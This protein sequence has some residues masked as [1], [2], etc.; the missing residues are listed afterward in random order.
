MSK[1][2]YYGLKNQNE[3]MAAAARATRT[4]GGDDAVFCLLVGT[5]CTETDMG[6]FRDRHPD[7]LGVGLNQFDEI[8]FTDL[9]ARTRRTNAAKFR[10][11]YGVELRDL[12]LEDLAN[13]PYLSMACCRLAYILV[14]EPIP[15]S[16][17]GQAA[18]WKKYWNTYAENAAGTA[19]SYIND[20]LTFIPDN[21]N[22]SLSFW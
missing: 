10:K 13:D 15:N 22:L 2:V 3:I 20:W 12:V 7:K 9:Q 16:L 19:R 8:R 1:K 11:E 4:F 14:P 18:Y 17:T 6:T 21:K 5:A